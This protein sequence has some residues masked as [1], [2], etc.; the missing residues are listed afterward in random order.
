MERH[1]R[2]LE[3][4]V[5]PLPIGCNLSSWQFCEWVVDSIRNTGYQNNKKELHND[6]W[7]ER[8]IGEVIRCVIPMLPDD[9]RPR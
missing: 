8:I 1:E 6:D 2:C 4:R 9:N 3:E 5:H 7:H